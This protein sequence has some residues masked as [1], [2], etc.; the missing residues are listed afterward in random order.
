MHLSMH[1]LL[2]K[3]DFM[4][5]GS[6]DDINMSKIDDPEVHSSTSGL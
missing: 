6:K 4:T 5:I 1:C 2:R 3:W